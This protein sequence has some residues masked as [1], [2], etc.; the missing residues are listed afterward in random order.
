MRAQPRHFPAPLEMGMGEKRQ[1]ET[2]GTIFKGLQEKCSL[3]WFIT[4][5]CA[6]LNMLKRGK[7]LH[8]VP[9]FWTTLL[10][11]SIRYAGRRGQREGNRSSSL[12]ICS[13]T[14]LGLR[15]VNTAWLQSSPEAAQALDWLP[16]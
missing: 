13:P 11:K 14:Q 16:W 9:Y 15:L 5:H 3:C 6:A 7:E 4:G 2:Q 12:P 1:Q 8:T 10:G